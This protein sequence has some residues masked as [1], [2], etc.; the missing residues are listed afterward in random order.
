[1]GINVV[2]PVYPSVNPVYPQ[3]KKVTHQMGFFKIFDLKRNCNI[4][5]RNKKVFI[6]LSKLSDVL[7]F[8]LIQGIAVVQCPT[9]TH[10]NTVTY[11]VDSDD[12]SLHK[13]FTG[14]GG[15]HLT[16]GVL[17]VKFFKYKMLSHSVIC[18]NRDALMAGFNKTFQCW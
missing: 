6:A 7:C 14:F 16:I 13:D 12:G 15:R 2:F 3:T 8:C 11:T 10:L 9:H 4:S 1:M 17:V 5:S 18:A